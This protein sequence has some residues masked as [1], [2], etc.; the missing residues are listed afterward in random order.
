MPSE[1]KTNQFF[2]NALDKMFK[3]VG[4]DGFDEEFTKQDNW[5]QLR[6]WSEE[7]ERQYRNW[8]MNECQKQ[9]RMNKKAAELETGYFLLMWGWKTKYIAEEK[10]AS[11][12]KHKID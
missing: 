6:E 8:F 1:K 3:E 9:L 5:Y 4:F 2:R 12:E 10:N 7:Q 11:H